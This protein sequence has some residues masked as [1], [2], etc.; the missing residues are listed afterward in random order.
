M[1]Y[2]DNITK[3]VK[4]SFISAYKNKQKGKNITN[5]QIKSATFVSK[6]ALQI[7]H[8]VVNEGRIKTLVQKVDDYGNKMKGEWLFDAAIVEVEER[9]TDYRNRR[10]NYIKRIIWAIESEFSINIEDFLRD[11]SK[12][13][14]VKADHY[15][16]INGVNQ[17][18]KDYRGNYIKAQ[19]QLAREIVKDAVKTDF[20]I[21][22]VPSPGK[23]KKQGKSIWDS[24]D[25][26]ELLKWI[27]VEKIG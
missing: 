4:R 20:Y 10:G 18:G 22:F 27:H 12:L 6:L 13:I 26:K 16:Y 1:D 19:I 11:F 15:L 2:V 17:A 14:H 7:E 8:L 9:K 23:N 21:G 3:A 24:Y 25:L 5:N